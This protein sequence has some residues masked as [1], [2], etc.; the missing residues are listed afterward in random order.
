MKTRILFLAILLVLSVYACNKNDHGETGTLIFQGVSNISDL[1]NCVIDSEKSVKNENGVY[2]MHTTDIE[3]NIAEIWAA[4]ELVSEGLSDDFKWYKI[5]EGDQLKSVSEYLFTTDNLPVGEYKSL[6]I[7]FRNEIIR[8]AVYESNH[9]Q[10]VDMQGSLTETA[11]GDDQIIIHYFSKKG[12]HSLRDDGTFKCNSSGENIRGFWIKPNEVTTIYWQIGSPGFQF[13]DC[14]FTWDDVNNNLQY[15]CGVDGIGNF[16]CSKSGPMWTF[17]V[18]DGEEEPFIKDAVT[19]ID[20]NSYDAVRIGNQIWL[21][22]NL[23][24]KHL[25]DGTPIMTDDEYNQ[26]CEESGNCLPPNVE[27]GAPL[28]GFPNNMEEFIGIFGL[29]YNWA[30]V[31]SGKLCPE[32]WHIPSLKEWNTLITF[33]GTNAGGKLKST[34]F[35]PAY[36]NWQSP[37]TGATDEYDFSALPAGTNMGSSSHLDYLNVGYGRNALFFSSDNESES[38]TLPNIPFIILT[39][40]SGDI[41]IE[42]ATYDAFM[43]C[44]CIK[45]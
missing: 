41:T 9:N 38:E 8:K 25:N 27:L 33:L 11:C 16:D 2:T 31:K 37:N 10:S 30:A 34:G 39:N 19:D 36:L 24:T 23:K 32:G 22:E 29:Y 44:R 45:D 28:L 40:T 7:A 14:W 21:N 5:G 20:G 43:S 18:D 4:Q 42:R 13:T 1:K 12:N 26:Y 15:D 3:V 17:G 35:E 6:K